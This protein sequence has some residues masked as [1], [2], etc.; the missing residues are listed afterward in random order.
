VEIGAAECVD[1]LD[2]DAFD[3]LLASRTTEAE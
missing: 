2:D 3:V 1:D